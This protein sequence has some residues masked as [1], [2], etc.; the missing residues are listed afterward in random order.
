MKVPPGNSGWTTVLGGYYD[1]GVNIYA[2]SG[3]SN[4]AVRVELPGVHTLTSNTDLR[5]NQWH[6]VM[7]IYDG[8]ALSI[9]ID[10]QIEISEEAS[11]NIN[12]DNDGD[13]Y[14]L[15]LGK[16]NHYGEY[17]IGAMAYPELWNIALSTET[18]QSHFQCP[19]RG[20]V[21]GLVA[22]WQF[23][24][25]N[26]ALVPD[27]SGTGRMDRF[28]GRSTL[29]M[30]QADCALLNAAWVRQTPSMFNCLPTRVYVGRERSGTRCWENVLGK[31]HLKTLVTTVQFGAR[32]LGL[33]L[34]PTP[35]ILTS[36][37]ALE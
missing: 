15:Y 10:G 6:H 4:G 17:F 18:I 13:D 32:R 35:P 5:D 21:D 24:E 16:G 36:T 23:D 31:F 20:E 9:W 22:L 1:H 26:G 11:G 33:A 19:P 29:L 27:A 37:A 7:V 3:N 30:C 8:S 25:N 2:G 28:S 14:D 12:P 34:W